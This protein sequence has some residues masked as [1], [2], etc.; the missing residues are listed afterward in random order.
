VLLRGIDAVQFVEGGT[1]QSET[2]GT[3]IVPRRGVNVL[4]IQL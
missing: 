4:T 2:L 1:A 3:R